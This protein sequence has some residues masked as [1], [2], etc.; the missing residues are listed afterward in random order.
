MIFDLDTWQEIGATVRSNPLRTALTA[1]GVFWGMFMLL[2][3]LGFGDGLEKAAFRMLGGRATNAVFVWGGR[4]S[5]AYRGLQPGRYVQYDNRDIAPLNALPG[6]AVL[7][8]RNQLGG[9]RDGTPVV[10]GGKTGA[11]QIMGDMPQFAAIQTVEFDGGRFINPLDISE[12]RKVA[13]LGE[14][15]VEALYEPGEP[16]LG[17]WIHVRGVVFQ[18]IGYFHS[19]APDDSGDRA[20]QTIHVPLSTFQQAFNR[21]DD[22]QWFAAV[23]DDDVPGTDLEAQVKAVLKDRHDVHPDDTEALGSFNSEREFRRIQNLFLGIRGLVW[24]VGSATLLSGV[25]GVSNI[26]LIVVRERTREIGLRRAVG[27]TPASIVGLI[28]QEAVVLTAISGLA[29]VVAGVAVVQ[30]AAWGIGADNPSMG[31]PGVEL[32]AALGASGVLLIAGVL[33]GLLP[34]RHAVAIHPVDALRAE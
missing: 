1:A 23:A 22:V 17:T 8:P 3:M 15:V 14:Q 29:G 5:M 30:L 27:A 7:A 13:V 20:E 9:Y 10:R 25:V 28:V 18:V 26:M 31:Q 34:A 6:V 12:L 21:G 11:F 19:T 2:V 32:E 16:V 24:L 33:A 4:T